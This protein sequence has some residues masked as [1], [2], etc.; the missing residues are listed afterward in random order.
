M[1]EEKVK[2]FCLRKF[3]Y[4]VQ[5]KVAEAVSHIIEKK[6]VFCLFPTGGGKSNCYVLPPLLLDE[7][8]Y[9]VYCYHLQ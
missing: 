7:V 1:M 8:I 4:E 2:N 5:P 9:I 6:D 3:D